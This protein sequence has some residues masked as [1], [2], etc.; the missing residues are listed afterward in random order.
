MKKTFK[1]SYLWLIYAFLY[2]PL[3][4]AVYLSFNK[5]YLS[6]GWKGFTLDWYEKLLDN[7]KLMES[8]LNSLL[9]SGLSAT[10]ATIL[11]LIIAIAL[12]RY[13]FLGK[14]FVFGSLYILIMS[15]EIIMG[16]SFVVFFIF[17]GIPLGF[18]TLLLSHITFCLPYVV[19]TI[20]ARLQGFNM[21]IIEAAND[22][23]AEEINILKKIIIPMSMP[24]II[25]G[26]LM[27]FTLSLDDIIVSFFVSGS[28]FE[29][30][31]IKV[32]SMV[33]VGF[34]TEINALCAI[35]LLITFIV[36]FLCHFLIKGEGKK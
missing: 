17:I 15:P 20:L 13:K 3:A 34:K 5:N 28:S 4:V 6:V 27:S 36:A 21:H 30:L 2:L 16:V 29:I 26:W 22:L 31:P 19:V 11:G 24:G 33:R 32:Y 18:T 8:A 14:K 9:L 7:K 35:I 10:L 25:A 12:Y 23:G 1:I